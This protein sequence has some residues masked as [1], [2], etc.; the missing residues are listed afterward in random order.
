MRGGSSGE[1]EAVPKHRQMWIQSNQESVPRRL[2]ALTY[3]GPGAVRFQGHGLT[4]KGYE[5]EGVEALPQAR[6]A[7]P[8]VFELYGETLP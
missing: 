1:C 5:G 8:V 7:G 3:D 2:G 4:P 6:E